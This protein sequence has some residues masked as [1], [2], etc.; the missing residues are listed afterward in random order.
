MAICNSSAACEATS[1]SAHADSDLNFSVRRRLSRKG[2]A[3]QDSSSETE[4][5]TEAAAVEAEKPVGGVGSG[6]DQVQSEARVVRNG[7]NGVVEVAAKFAY[8]PS[9]PAHRRV[10]ESP[11]SSDAIFRQ[12]SE[13]MLFLPCART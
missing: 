6:G 10:K 5:E 4:A 7:E 8:R 9:A 13:L 2:K 12:V 3:V 11:L 1:S